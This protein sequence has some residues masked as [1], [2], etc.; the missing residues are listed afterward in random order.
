[1]LHM[2]VHEVGPLSLSERGPECRTRHLGPFIPNQL[3]MPVH[4]VHEE[5]QFAFFRSLICTGARRNPATCGT[6]Q[7]N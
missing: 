5:D 6:N 4:E 7:G 3:E 1:M 2:P